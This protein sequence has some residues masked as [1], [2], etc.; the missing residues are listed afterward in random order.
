MTNRMSNTTLSDLPLHFL[1]EVGKQSP[2]IWR[3]LVLSIPRVGRWSLDKDYQKHI[4]RHF[5]NCIEYFQYSKASL[6]EYNPPK[7]GKIIREYRIGNK[8]H[9]IDGPAVE[10]LNGEKFWFQNGK[11]HRDNDLP[12][13]EYANGDSYE[14]ELCSIQSGTEGSKQ[15]YQQGKCHRDNDLPAIEWV[16]GTKEWYQNGKLHRDNDLPAI[17][18]CNETKEWHQN[19]KLH[20]DNDLPAIEYINGYKEWW[21]NGKHQRDNR[22]GKML[23]FGQQWEILK[24]RS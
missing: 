7:D 17:Q 4:Q 11:L 16:N 3:V 12:A 20:R 13:I 18:Y 10:W 8:L 19:G 21:I 1:L 22:G 6:A 14:R 5:T 9:N 23:R 15:W 24:Y 2:E